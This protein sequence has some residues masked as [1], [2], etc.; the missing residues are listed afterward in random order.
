[1]SRTKGAK[2]LDHEAKRRDLLEKI[3][4]HLMARGGERASFRDLAAA[5]EVSPP[6][7]RH[8][9][10]DRLAV[11][12]A[13]L[14]ECLRR[15]RPGL[16]AQRFVP[17]PSGAQPGARLYATGD[18]VRQRQDGALEFL[19]RLD[20]QVKVRGF[21]IEPGEVEEA[22]RAAPNVAEACV[23][24]EPDPSG[25]LQLLAFVTARPGAPIDPLAL[26][27]ALEA[28][29]PAW[30]VPGHLQ[31]VEALPRTLAGKVDRRALL[32]LRAQVSSQ[33]GALEGPIEPLL[34]EL[35]R[36]LLQRQAVFAD[37]DLIA[38]RKSTRLNSSHT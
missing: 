2:D 10:G 37:D 4:L 30:M 9:F 24:T 15:G 19:G 38:D 14:E 3:T 7:L 26:R 33:G 25:A 13:V 6:T 23:L 28:Q 27:A 1:L 18:R 34:A 12:D 22:L 21:R 8:Y 36:G 20:D 17:D 32:A 5:A 11:I 16:T 29:L 35:W 31:A